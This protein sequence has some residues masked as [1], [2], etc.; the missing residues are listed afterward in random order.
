MYIISLLYVFIIVGFI[1][2]IYLIVPSIE[3]DGDVSAVNTTC[4]FV[5][6]SF[7]FSTESCDT[8]FAVISC[9]SSIDWLTIILHAVVCPE[10]DTRLLNESISYTSDGL[11]RLTGIPQVCSDDMV[12]GCQSVLMALMI[13]PYLLLSVNRTMDTDASE[14]FIQ[15]TVHNYSHV[16][17]DSWLLPYHEALLYG[18]SLHGTIYINGVYCPEIIENYLED[19]IWQCVQMVDS[20]W[21]NVMIMKV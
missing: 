8:G 20:M 19:W 7:Q 12:D 14:H 9:G 4:G 6:Y 2:W 1:N 11:E 3:Y 21:L 18:L 5:E 13:R 17:I 16:F 15:Y 10:N